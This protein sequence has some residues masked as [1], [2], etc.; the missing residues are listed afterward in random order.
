M[1]KVKT[2]SMVSKNNIKKNNHRTTKAHIIW[3]VDKLV[4]Y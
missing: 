4:S 3:D 2:H 1:K